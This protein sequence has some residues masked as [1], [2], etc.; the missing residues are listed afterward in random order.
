[1]A[2]SIIAG[3]YQKVKAFQVDNGQLTNPEKLI[4]S[5]YDCRWPQGSSSGAVKIS[6]DQLY[7]CSFGIP[8]EFF[9]E[10][11]GFD[12]ICD[13]IGM[14]DAH[15]G[16]RLDWAGHE[17]MYDRAMLTIELDDPSE[18]DPTHKLGKVCRTRDRLN[19]QIER[20]DYLKKLAHFGVYRRFF[21]DKPFD[22]SWM[23][24]DLLYGMRT[25]QT[26]LN[27]Y[28]LADLNSD[29]LALLPDRFSSK[30]WFND[31][32]LACL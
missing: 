17:I 4:V 18:A 22:A 11:N 14:E 5:S 6:G 9:L 10:V 23:V 15:L 7:G 29:N 8:K 27:P 24:L 13:P 25:S 32:E 28:L 16:M 21:K 12:E 20:L 31:Q 30:Y 2:R 3:A 26:L 1:M 19:L